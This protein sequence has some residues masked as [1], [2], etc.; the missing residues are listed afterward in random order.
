MKPSNFG[1]YALCSCVAAALLA[2]CGG[3]QPPIG[4]PGAMLPSL[5]RP[6]AHGRDLLY[7]TGGSTNIFTFPKGQL[8]SNFGVTGGAMCSNLAGDVFIVTTYGV[9]EYPHGSV[10]QIALIPSPGRPNSCSVDPTTGNLAVVFEASGSNGVA[11]FRPEHHHRWQAPRVYPFAYPQQA[12]SYDSVGNLFVGGFT[13]GSGFSLVEL[14][15]G[16]SAF[17]TISLDTNV[18]RQGDLQWDGQYLAIGDGT[19]NT[20]IHRF[21]I[22]GTKGKQ[23]GSLMLS[24]VKYI[25]Q[26]WIQGSILVGTD[27]YNSIVGFWRYPQGGVPF[28]RLKVKRPVSGVTV[29]LVRQ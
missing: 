9:A 8:V 20:V 1:R 23:I 25:F 29:S 6:D 24:H 4:A 17:E 5:I 27:G 11:V 3:S 15:K 22:Q 14:P 12:C 7:V 26:F 10:T 16:Q 21:A 19:G 18:T 2:A 13:S 28:K